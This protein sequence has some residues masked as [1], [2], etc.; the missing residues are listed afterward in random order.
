MSRSRVG[1][2]SSF[3]VVAAILMALIIP[4][5]AYAWSQQY[6]NGV[7]FHPDAAGFSGFNSNLKYNHVSWYGEGGSTIMQL[8]LCNSGGS[9]YTYTESSSGNL[10]DSRTIS[11]GRAKCHSKSSNFY[12]SHIYECYTNN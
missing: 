9:C 11:Y 1:H 2:R 7:V 5:V 3:L 10:A 4:A 8:S 6:E 12:D